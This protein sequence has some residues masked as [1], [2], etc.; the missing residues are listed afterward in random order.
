MLVYLPGVGARRVSDYVSTIDLG[1]TILSANG[2][3]S[4]KEYLGVSLLPLMRGE[5]FSRPPVYGE[6]TGE[7]ISP[8]VQFHQQIHP[9]TK[10][11]MAIAQDGFKMIFNRDVFSFELYDLRTDPKE[12][13]NLYGV[14]PEKAI[15]M[16]RFVL[17]YVDIVTASRP[18]NADEGRYS[19]ATGADGDKVED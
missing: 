18:W 15:E 5:A 4:P 19:K 8:H 10:K 12:E 6:Q 13:R 11:Y 9:E 1:S 17:Q 16:R 14:M 3:D 2:L 7:E